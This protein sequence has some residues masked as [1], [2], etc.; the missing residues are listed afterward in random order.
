M[1]SEPQQDAAEREP[2]HDEPNDA[3]FAGAATTP[4]PTPERSDNDG[5]GEQI[6]VPAGDLTGSLMAAI[7]EVSEHH[8]DDKCDH[9]ATAHEGSVPHSKPVGPRTAAGQVSR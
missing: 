8:H 2:E 3:G 5:F 4:T 1:T 6:A 9:A 7:E